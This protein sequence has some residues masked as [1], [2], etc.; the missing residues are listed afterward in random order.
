MILLSEVKE[1]CNLNKSIFKK[2]MK[3]VQHQIP[4]TEISSASD[5]HKKTR[6]VQLHGPPLTRETRASE[7]ALNMAH[8]YLVDLGVDCKHIGIPP[9]RWL[10]RCSI[11][12]VLAII[13]IF[14]NVVNRTIHFHRWYM[15]QFQPQY[16][17]QSL[18]WR[19]AEYSYDFASRFHGDFVLDQYYYDRQ[20]V[21]SGC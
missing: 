21:G 11:L 17:E 18:S 1:P 10:S 5:L 20:Y 19:I 7:S 16:Q 3:F 12:L 6:S 2:T 8:G 4:E 9:R 14:L 13:I 15:P